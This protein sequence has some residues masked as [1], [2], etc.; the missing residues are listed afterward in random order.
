M[1]LGSSPVAVT[2]PL[3][4]LYWIIISWTK[5]WTARNKHHFSYSLKCLDHARES[6]TDALKTASKKAFRKRAESTGDLIN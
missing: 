1:V 3:E 6:A 2:L 4:L 5:L